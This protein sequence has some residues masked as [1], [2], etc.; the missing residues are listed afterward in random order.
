MKAQAWR[1]HQ[2]IAMLVNGSGNYY[3]YK[4]CSGCKNTK[5]KRPYPTKYRCEEC[6]MEHGTGFWP[7]NTV[8]KV[9]GIDTLAE[10]H[11]R[12]HSEKLIIGTP[13]P[14]GSATECSVISDSTEE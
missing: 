4:K 2:S 1:R 5:S 11:I 12:Y 6:S 14:I 8:K 3:K 10:C 9:G 7:C 13:P